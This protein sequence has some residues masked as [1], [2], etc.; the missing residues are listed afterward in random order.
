MLDTDASRDSL[1]SFTSLLTEGDNLAFASNYTNR[2]DTCM[3]GG[4]WWAGGGQSQLNV[5]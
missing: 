3:V 5:H 1:A 2:H 4:G